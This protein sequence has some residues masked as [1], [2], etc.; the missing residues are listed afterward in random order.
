MVDLT[1]LETLKTFVEDP[2][3][4]KTVEETAR[5]FYNG[6]S[7]TVNLLPALAIL[8]LGLLALAPLL[9]IPLLPLLSGIVGGGSSSGS[10]AYGAPATG[11]GDAYSRADTDYYQ[12]TITDLQAQIAAL[13]DSEL[14]L[15][16]QLYYS[17]S[18][19]PTSV[20][21]NQIGYSS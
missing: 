17:A 12:T 19:A 11:Y 18:N 21:S 8:G 2:T 20:T 6:D 9:G 7:I 13:Q 15:R 3:V 1:F 16:N 5:I 10:G 14:E 4:Q